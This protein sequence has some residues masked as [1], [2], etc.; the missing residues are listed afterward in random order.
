VGV[1]RRVLLKGAGAVVVVGGAGSA[2]RAWDQGVFSV[3]RG[4]AYEAWYRWRSDP[5]E[6]PVALVRAAVLA[7][8]PHNSQPWLFRVTDSCVDLFAD[9]SRNLGPIDPDLREMYVGLGCALENLLLTAD[10]LGYAWQLTLLPERG[11]PT[12]AARIALGPGRPTSVALYEAIPRRHT[13]RGPYDPTRP[14]E[15]DLLD[16]IARTAGEGVRLLRF[17][18]ERDRRR[19]GN[20]IVRA[21]EAVVADE[22]QSWASARW[23]RLRWPDVQ[24]YRD[25]ITVDANITSPVRRA[26]AKMLPPLSREAGDQFWLAATRETFVATAAGFGMHIVRNAHD[27]AQRLCGGRAW[28]R[29]HLAATA[30]GLALQPPNQPTERADREQ[31]LGITRTFGKALGELVGDRAWEALMTFRIGY[32]M[33]AA[34]FSPRRAAEAVLIRPSPELRPDLP[35]RGPLI[36][37]PVGQSQ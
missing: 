26:V 31:T 7:A 9:P 4:P 21:T 18:D 24:R 8:N 27:H 12:H 13:N 3:G 1:A 33:R 5:A 2:W 35:D 25:G 22:G 6:G 16:D 17:V 28:Q 10:A 30:H 15:R 37:R 29:L 11:N 36:A 23:L 14:V 32:P 34:A 19:L 20:L